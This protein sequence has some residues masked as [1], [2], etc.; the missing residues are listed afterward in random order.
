LTATASY[1][2]SASD[3]YTDRYGFAAHGLSAG[4][5][6]GV[7]IEK[8][9]RKSG[10]GAIN[11]ALLVKRDGVVAEGLPANVPGGYTVFHH[12]FAEKPGGGNWSLSDTMPRL[13]ASRCPEW[14]A[15]ARRRPA[16]PSPTPGC[17]R[18]RWCAVQTT[19]ALLYDPSPPPRGGGARISMLCQ[20]IG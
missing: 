19:V 4:T 2:E 6:H 8:L 10:A 9:A 15:F 17:G 7:I 20:I 16:S 14:Q 1:V 18:C 11:V 12:H 5:P 13:S 3:G